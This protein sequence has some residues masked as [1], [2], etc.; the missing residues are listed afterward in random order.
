MNLP[1]TYTAEELDVQA[2][3]ALAVFV[4]KRL[5][6]G[7]APYR[8]AFREAREVVQRMFQ[9]TDNLR[10]LTVEVVQDS[11][12]LIEPARYLGGPPLSQD[13]LDTLTGGKIAHRKS[14]DRE[15]ASRA[16]DALRSFLDPFRC[17]WLAGSQ[18]PSQL[19]LDAAI[20]WT[21]SLWAV[22]RCKTSRRGE[23]SSMQEKA[24]AAM[25]HQCG[26]TEAKRLRRIRSLDELS[27]DHF[28]REVI[29]G[30]AKADLAVRLSDGRFLAV[31]CKVSNSALNS[32]KRLNR[33]TVGKAET[34]RTLYGQQVVTAAVLGGVYKVSNL[35]DA[36][37]A[38]VFIFW[39]HDLDPLEAFVR[40]TT[41]GASA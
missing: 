13:D 1:N 24:V 32:V 17:P 20:D 38:G 3:L 21:A 27:R 40:R 16:V 28:T 36:Q 22:E 34:W 39:E 7:T 14:V 41:S 23:S 5:K 2:R 33:E 4:Q 9:A 6:E 10:A 35:I 26:L 11:P 37:K 31:E 12:W 15:T 19:Q 18:T 30:N 25:F 29:V 8:A